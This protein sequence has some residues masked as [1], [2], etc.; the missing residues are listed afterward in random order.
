[1]P[2]EDTLR[3]LAALYDRSDDPWDHRTSPTE[4]AKYAATLQA[5]G[6]GPFRHAVEVGCGNGTLLARLAPRCQRLTGIDCIPRAADAARNAV[7]DFPQV[8]VIDGAAPKALQGLSPDLLVLSE[9]L[10]FLTP[11]EIGQLSAWIRQT[12]VRTVAVNWL[13]P[14]DEDLDGTTAL[15]CLTRWLGAPDTTH[16]AE[17]YRIDVFGI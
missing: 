13:G 15:D 9:V 14:T 6:P 12:P 10:Y 17:T 8:E 4:Q 1:M 7:S 3:H 5:I 11:E 2:R 16:V